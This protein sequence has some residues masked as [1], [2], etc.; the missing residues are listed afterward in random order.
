M[1]ITDP[2]EKTNLSGRTKGALIRNGF[3]TIND[4]LQLSEY[5]LSQIDHLGPM[6]VCEI[7]EFIQDFGKDGSDPYKNYDKWISENQ[8]K[9]KEYI[10][11]KDVSIEDM[12]LTTRTY[13]I[14]R[15]NNKYHLSD[16]LGVD[17]ATLKHG[18]LGRFGTEEIKGFLKDY[19]RENRPEIIAFVG[20]DAAASESLQIPDVAAEAPVEQPVALAQ[21][22]D[23]MPQHT[24]LVRSKVET[25]PKEYVEE[26]MEQPHIEHRDIDPDTF[27]GW[28]ELN[29]GVISD[30]VQKNN[31]L[32]N[33]SDL[34]PRTRNML[35]NMIG[36]RGVFR[37]SDFLPLNF[38]TLKNGALR[39]AGAQEVCNV[40][41]KYVLDN[42][43]EIAA[44]AAS[45]RKVLTS[46][47]AE[48]PQTEP[49][50]PKQQ[51]KVKRPKRVVI[52]YAEPKE[53][54]ATVSP[55]VKEDVSVHHPE[56]ED[57][58]ADEPI[59]A[60]IEKDKQKIIAYLKE[61]DVSYKEL[62]LSKNV[63]YML[64]RTW[65]RS[66]SRLFLH[67][68]DGF[69]GLDGIG[70]AERREIS[71]KL[72]QFINNNKS[73]YES[74]YES[75]EAPEQV[76]TSYSMAQSEEITVH[77]SIANNPEE[78]VAATSTEPETHTQAGA[79]LP[80]EQAPVEVDAVGEYLRM[81][82]FS[83]DE[84]DLSL[85]PYNALRKAGIHTIA[86]LYAMPPEAY[87]QLPGLGRGSQE[88]IKTR[89]KTFLR[90][91]QVHNAADG[92]EEAETDAQQPAILDAVG[93]Y[94]RANAFSLDLLG[95][96]TRPYN[97]LRR[98]GIHTIVDLYTIHPEDYQKFPNLGKGS[99]EEIEKKL[100]AFLRSKQAH[101]AASSNGE[102][103]LEPDDTE[104]H[105]VEDT[106]AEVD[107]DIDQHISEE[108]AAMTVAELLGHKQ[109]AEFVRSFYQTFDIPVTKLNL[110]VRSFN[111]MVKYGYESFSKILTL[112]PDGF[113][114]LRGLGSLS[115]TE[116]KTIIESTVEKH[117]EK[118]VGF[119]SS[120]KSA[121]Y[122][123]DYIRETVLAQFPQNAFVGLSF[124]ELRKEF[125]EDIEDERI[126]TAVGKLLSEHV[127]EYVDYRVYRVY[128]SFYEVLDAVEAELEKDEHEIVSR[129]FSGL[130]LEAIGETFDVS[131]ERI[132]QKLSKALR[133]VKT[134][135]ACKNGLKIFDEDYYAYLYSNYEI[136][137]ECWFDFIGI[138]Q[139]TYT[140][141]REC[142]KH[143]SQNLEDVLEDTSVDISLKFKIRDYLNRNKIIVDG[144]MMDA[145]RAVLENFI[146]SRY[147]KDDTPYE[148]FFELF[149]GVLQANGIPYN[150]DIY[151][152]EEIIRSRYN[153][154]AESRV[155]L[156][157]QGRMLR[158]YD[159]DGSDFTELLDTI[160]LD[161]FENT[162][163]STLKF[164]K[165][166]PELMQKYDIRDQY[167]LHNLLKKTVDEGAYHNIDFH[168][169]PVITF[170][171]FDRE[172]AIEEI[173]F[174]FAPISQE[175][176]AEYIYDEYGY[177][178]TTII[179][180]YLV[181]FSK[182]YHNGMYSVDFKN[183]PN[184]RKALFADALTEDFYFTEDVK[185]L[186][187]K[188][189]PGADLE[190][191]NPYSLKSMGF[192]V[193]S[194]YV[195]QHYA[196][197]VDFFKHVLT[198][199]DV[200]ST[201]GELKRYNS[202]T[203]YSQIFAEL[204]KNYDILAFDKDEYINFRRL[205]KL[206]FTKEAIHSFCEEVCEAVEEETYFTMRSLRNAGFKF[207]L[208]AL[209]FDDW[210]FS[211]IL[212]MS[213]KFSYQRVYGEVVLY[214]TSSP[215]VFS[216]NTFILAL[217]SEYESVNVDDF[218]DDCK[219][220]YGIEI[221][222][223][224]EVTGAVSGTSFYYDAIMG[225][226]YR[227]KSLYYE[228][229]DD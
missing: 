51:E 57:A 203:I 228:E 145:T 21:S 36:M 163:V 65:V 156:W 215:T 126:K 25:P 202:I 135:H 93:E 187:A 219:Y 173:L 217:L 42:F 78:T 214:K 87:L 174:A 17:P 171:E 58:E 124:K 122:T 29:K 206:G 95:L 169:Q 141:L 170:G 212:A 73:L 128:P 88:E 99:Q 158:Y 66:V 74:M 1:R 223:K 37:L 32:I 98:A 76:S 34:C 14:L 112:Y 19:L 26:A 44:L 153:R 167:E 180:T 7:V 138:S 62:G 177:D 195:V 108:I 49:E 130:T 46:M 107:F 176:L 132:R 200:F 134:I 84:L 192:V 131:R 218:I 224:Y 71:E 182:Y 120:N 117:R 204:R 94:L 113:F 199:D 208:D 22:H 69:K 129:K 186:Y 142:Y 2:I 67:Y 97:A 75:K 127:L 83:I 80:S 10:C 178:K 3:R 211:N 54:L 4:I 55:V 114:A 213:G 23:D 30:Y 61:N 189:F 196:T 6:A 188:M 154:I 146:I 27:E 77:D 125:P 110:S 91:K 181:P 106:L 148:E 31:T 24:L 207:D 13:N 50:E 70:K 18:V 47:P 191:V 16:L 11:G 210:F 168:R 133:K 43:S 137:K 222:R 140:Y 220:E 48:K 144:V 172:K 96:S 39:E 53:E 86:D 64:R 82:A 136:S 226:I 20:A 149:N 164:I 152:T 56:T 183:I 194:N 157:K 103:K 68:L 33:E 89:L 79:M 15:M 40:V 72:V 105:N 102:I 81:N 166:Y 221:P 201:R 198:K 159:L 92:I 12:D 225:K 119:C 155:C 185:K 161:S 184:D 193:L 63:D 52:S 118:I 162:E 60:E 8:E 143:G 229:F 109:Y 160:N 115:I 150:K 227:S 90:S 104:A 100:D 190:E 205:E 111:A 151:Y 5:E 85:R 139:R 209:G 9:V 147:C 38:C 45:T 179:A 59:D 101:I 175:E 28:V 165:K 197:A 41:K 35:R 216:I 116:I 123:D 121:M